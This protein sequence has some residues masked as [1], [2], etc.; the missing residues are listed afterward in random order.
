MLTKLLL[1]FRFRLL[2][3]CSLSSNCTPIFNI[4]ATAVTFTNSMPLSGAASVQGK[5]P[6]NKMPKQR[7]SGGG[8]VNTMFMVK[9]GINK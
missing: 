8:G 2:C 1:A 3:E 5:G 6:K 4:H 7:S 9:R